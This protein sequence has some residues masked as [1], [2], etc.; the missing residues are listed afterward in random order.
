MARTTAERRA[1]RR[2]L[3]EE[4]WAREAISRELDRRFAASAKLT[5]GATS[6]SHAVQCTHLA[7]K[8]ALSGERGP[9]AVLYH[10]QSLR[11]RVGPDSRPPLYATDSYLPGPP[12]LADPGAVDEA[13]RIL[14]AADRPGIIAGN[15]VRIRQADEE[16]PARA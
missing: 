15:G 2:L 3:S 10:S 5:L 9:V 7:I 13:V 12:P 6:G 14:I 1:V 4:E 16:L 8:H 11:G